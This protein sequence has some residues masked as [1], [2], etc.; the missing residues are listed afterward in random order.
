MK[1]RC[2]FC[3]RP[4]E[5][6]VMIGSEAVGPKCAKKQGL[7]P[8]KIQS[9]PRIRFLK[10]RPSK[11]DSQNLDLFYDDHNASLAANG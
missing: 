9:S 7:M 2:V 8:D 3:N 10:Y 6:F 11:P 1:P 4:T 5:P